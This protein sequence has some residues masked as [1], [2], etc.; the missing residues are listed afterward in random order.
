MWF[1][2]EISASVFFYFLF[3]Y[4]IR[5]EVSKKVS[6]NSFGGGRYGNMTVFAKLFCGLAHQKTTL[7]FKKKTKN[8]HTITKVPNYLL[9]F[10]FYPR[11]FQTDLHQDPTSGA[12]SSLSSFSLI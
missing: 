5:T 12:S 3:L 1:S 2:T 11:N 9:R 8:T 6:W 4:D 7:P 10:H